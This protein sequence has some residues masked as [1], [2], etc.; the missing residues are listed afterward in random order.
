MK[1]RAKRA[2]TRREEDESERRSLQ[3]III[4]NM[5]HSVIKTALALFFSSSTPSL[6][7]PVSI[8]SVLQTKL[9]QTEAELR[10]LSKE[11]QGLRNSLAQR[12]TSVLQLQSTITTLTQ[13]LTTAH[14]K[15]VR[16]L[17]GDQ[18]AKNNI[19]IDNY[20]AELENVACKCLIWYLLK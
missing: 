5:L 3:V 17:F 19:W 9:E 8:I 18:R 16:H 15:E 7:L 6:F 11:F 10:S 12:D 4:Q 2:G 1:E 20:K 13:K 14:R